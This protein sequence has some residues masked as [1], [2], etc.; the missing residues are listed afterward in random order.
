ML[1][2]YEG[3]LTV[4]HPQPQ[5][6]WVSNT[7]W[8][9]HDGRWRPF[10]KPLSLASQRQALVILH[11]LLQWAT[12][13]HYLP[14]NPAT[15]LGKI[16]SSA[17]QTVERYLPMAALSYLR[18]AVTNLPDHTTTAHARKTRAHFLLNLFYL[19]GARLHEVVGAT[20]TSIRC[21]AHGHWW[22]HVLGKGD[23]PGKMPVPLALL[24]SF[25]AYRIAL[26]LPA[27]PALTEDTVPLVLVRY[28]S[29][30]SA[31]DNT[32]YKII[33]ELMEQAA[34]LAIADQ[35]P[36]LA[37]RLKLASPHWLRHSC[38]THQVEANVP[39]KTV[40]E[41]ARHA[42]LVTTGHYVHK[43]DIDRHRE[44]VTALQKILNNK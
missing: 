28:G 23:K 30:D 34:R 38:F 20:M 39:L 27:L 32:V 10:N 31:T 25:T 11:G 40:Q 6:I 21:D 15:L 42:S 8:S 22:F 41:N 12:D 19:T 13:A 37:Q 1:L 3:I 9:R 44:T 24:E 33:R 17:R 29:S 14:A 43:N 26:S 4:P 7:R 18:Q 35:Q 5:E 2:I 36:E 16:P